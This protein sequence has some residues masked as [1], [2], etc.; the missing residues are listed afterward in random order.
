MKD[1]SVTEMLK[2]LS[3]KGLVVYTLYRGVALTDA[4]REIGR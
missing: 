2:N 3:E 1:A 4:G